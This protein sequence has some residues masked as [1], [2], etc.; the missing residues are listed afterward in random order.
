MDILPQGG[1]TIND[2][3]EI[4]GEG[5]SEFIFGRGWLLEMIEIKRGEYCF[6]SDGEKVVPTSKRFG[7]FY[8]PFTFIRAFVRKVTGTVYGVGDIEPLPGLPNKPVIFRADHNAPFTR[9]DEA[10]DVLSYA[11]DVRSIEVNTRPSLLSIKTKRLIDENF[12][13]YPAI[14]RI[15][16]RLKVSHEHLTR[17]FKS[18]Y[19]ITPSKYLHQLRVSEATFRL[20][21]GEEII[22]ISQDVGYNDLSRFY[23][24]FRKSTKTSP[25][26][27]REMLRR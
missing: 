20:A 9:A 10:L 21:I 1:Y 27:C 17:Q 6:Y 25:A 23:K 22:D 12:L 26:A 15:A 7:A 16:D 19:G 5:S 8:P 11:Q 13:V 3:F 4:A 24:Q 18:D 14:S 2:R